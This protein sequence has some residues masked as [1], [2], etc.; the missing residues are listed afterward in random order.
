MWSGAGRTVA[1]SGRGARRPAPVD[2]CGLRGD[3]PARASERPLR[4]LLLLLK[5][6]HPTAPAEHS[7][8][9][10]RTGEERVRCE[11]VREEASAGASG[12]AAA[13]SAEVVL[14]K[15][16]D[17]GPTE[18]GRAEKCNEDLQFPSSAFKF[19]APLRRAGEAEG[20]RTAILRRHLLR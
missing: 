19:T 18:M 3:A 16:T 17:T 20:V 12:E 13:G 14:L 1:D 8:S 5:R 10:H 4:L 11:R 2:D 7:H 6:A 9:V 15:R